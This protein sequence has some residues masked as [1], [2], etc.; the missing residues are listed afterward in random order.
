MTPLDELRTVEA[1]AT[2]ADLVETMFRERHTGYPVFRNGEIAGIVTLE[3]ARD[4]DPV[5]REA[6]LVE[7]VMTTDLE[8]VPADE[9]VMEAFDRMQQEGIGRLLVTQGGEVVGLVSRTD[10]MTAFDVI[11]NSGAL[12]GE[13]GPP[14]RSPGSPD[15]GT[16]R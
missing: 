6:F 5:E 7:D 11:R 3:D 10:I 4:V 8:T 9:N 16:A 15:T 1:E 13:A 14:A 12:A 2:I